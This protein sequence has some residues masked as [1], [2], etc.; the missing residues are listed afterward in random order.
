MSIFDDNNPGLVNVADQA[1]PPVP[2]TQQSLPVPRDVFGSTFAP[3]PLPQLSAGAPIATDAF[4]ANAGGRA[5]SFS[6]GLSA[7]AFP[8]SNIAA[9]NLIKTPVA[10]WLVAPVGSFQTNDAKGTQFAFKILSVVVFNSGLPTQAYQIF[11]QNPVNLLGFGLDLTELLVSFPSAAPVS[12]PENVP[13]RPIVSY[14]GNWIFLNAFD[15][16]GNLLTIPGFNQTVQ[17]GILREGPDVIN[18]TNLPV[19]N[20]VVTA[21]QAPPPPVLG[22]VQ[23]FQGTFQA[24]SGV[25]L[26]FIGSGTRTPP[27]LGTFEVE[28]QSLVG[29]GLPANVF[30]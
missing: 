12:A 5:P 20:V 4:V 9:Q 14:N 1:Y 18:K 30:V 15:Q 3:P 27:L 25:V 11:L 29:Q 2:A 26:P 8:D 10:D 22:T 19:I 21:P 16:F 13:Q 7:P 24:N 28:N 17:I 23:A 6:L